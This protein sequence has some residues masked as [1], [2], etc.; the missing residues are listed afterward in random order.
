MLQWQ[1]VTN[2]ERLDSQ[3]QKVNQ[4]I[5]QSHKVECWYP[6]RIVLKGR[7]DISWFKNPQGIVSLPNQPHLFLI[8]RVIYVFVIQNSQHP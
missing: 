8:L 2:R 3:W 7:W 1:L 4:G 6:I 5:P